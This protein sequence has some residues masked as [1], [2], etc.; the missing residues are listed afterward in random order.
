M[1]VYIYIHHTNRFLIS[2]LYTYGC[3]L[4]CNPHL[5]KNSGVYTIHMHE[6]LKCCELIIRDRLS[7]I[8]STLSS[9]SS[10][11][12]ADSNDDDY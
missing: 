1:T 10:K 9:S 6:Y 7:Y 8:A 3:R 12:I 4:I 2:H 5:V 11:V